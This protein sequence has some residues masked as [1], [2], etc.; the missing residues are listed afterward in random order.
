MRCTRYFFQAASAQLPYI[1]VNLRGCSWFRNLG[2]ISEGWN[3]VSS[4]EEINLDCEASSPPTEAAYLPRL[5]GGSAL[6]LH[7]VFRHLSPPQRNFK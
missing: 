3:F 5:R 6:A 2:S 4:D 1:I 7:L